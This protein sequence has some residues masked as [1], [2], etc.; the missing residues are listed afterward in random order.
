MR[1]D[2]DNHQ[3][4]G[5]IRD[6]EDCGNG[7]PGHA[8]R[9]PWCSRP[10]NLTMAPIQF[11]PPEIETGGAKHYLIRHVAGVMAPRWCGRCARLCKGLPRSMKEA[12][13]ELTKPWKAAACEPAGS[14]TPWLPLR[15]AVR[16]L[17]WRA[18][19]YELMVLSDSGQSRWFKRY[20]S[21][22]RA[23]SGSL[24]GRHATACGFPVTA[25]GG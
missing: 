18:G 13:R 24:Q 12:W 3:W 22:M 25:E 21:E 15:V 17:S 11:R 10:C 5:E 2:P 1:Q 9:A 8:D 20:R 4:S 6:L 19:V 14:T 16:P 7:D 23:P